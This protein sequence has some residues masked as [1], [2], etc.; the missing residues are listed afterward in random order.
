MIVILQLYIKEEFLYFFEI[1]IEKFIDEII[2]YLGYASKYY[3]RSK[4][5]GIQMKQDWP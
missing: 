3:G 4:W 5:M 2:W 1:A